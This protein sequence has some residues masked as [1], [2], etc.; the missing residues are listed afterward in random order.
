M[1]QYDCCALR[2]RIHVGTLLLA[3]NGRQAVRVEERSHRSG[4]VHDVGLGRKMSCIQ[5]LDV[6]VGEVV[7]ERLGSRGDE[8]GIAF[9]P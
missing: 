1:D 5:E 7:P 6:C 4:D 3:S 8:E 2:R 9:A